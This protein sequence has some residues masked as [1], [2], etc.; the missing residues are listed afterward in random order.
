VLLMQEAEPILTFR[1]YKKGQR[2]QVDIHDPTVRGLIQAKYLKIHWRES[3]DARELDSPLDP[4]GSSRIS[5]GGVDPDDSGD[6]QDA[7]EVDDGQGEHRPAAQDR[8]SA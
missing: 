8:D 5:A 7:E 3:G 4:A 6:P 2:I 1:G